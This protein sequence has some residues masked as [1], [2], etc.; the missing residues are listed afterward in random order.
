[1]QPDAGRVWALNKAGNAT[2]HNETRAPSGFGILGIGMLGLGQMEPLVLLLGLTASFLLALGLARVLLVSILRLARM[3]G[4][5]HQ[6]APIRVTP[7][8]VRSD[9]V[10]AGF[11]AA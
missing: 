5:F 3:G 2:G 1:M 9:L 6:T 11:L 7:A 8:A 10:S 4:Q